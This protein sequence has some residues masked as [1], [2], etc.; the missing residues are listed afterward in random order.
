VSTGQKLA[1][2]ISLLVGLYV[3]IA[4][5]RAIVEAALGNSM[6]LDVDPA[7]GYFFG[8]AGL[9]VATPLLAYAFLVWTRRR[10]PPRR[11]SRVQ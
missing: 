11:A 4:S 7:L 9:I 3:A 5:V 2:L 1:G 10:K 6:G 8:G